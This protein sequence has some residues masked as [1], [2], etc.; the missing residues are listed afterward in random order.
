M[1]KMLSKQGEEEDNICST[2]TSGEK[3]TSI[4]SDI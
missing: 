1:N 4:S 2:G 3:I